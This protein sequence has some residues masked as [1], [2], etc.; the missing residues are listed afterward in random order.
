MTGRIIKGIAGFYYVYVEGCGVYECKAKGVF[1]NRKVKPLVGDRVEIQVIDETEHKGNMEE[2]LPR[3]SE[4]IRPAVAN[5]DQAMVIFAAAK[6]KPNLSLLDRF[7]ISMAQKEVP[8]IICFNKIDEASEEELQR[9]KEIYGG[10]GS[11]LLFISARYEQGVE[12]I[13]DLLR[14]R[15]RQ[16]QA[17]QV[18][19]NQHLSICW[20]RTQRWR[21]DRSARRLTEE[22]I[23]HGTVNCSAWKKTAIFLILRVSVHW[24]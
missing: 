16:W 11:R 9:L 14:E 20:C 15:P 1:R 12:K 17:H 5:V 13:R 21:R 18:L 19:E 24:N 3:T 23:P 2:I 10:C 7:L 8:S 22:N 4:L 6:P